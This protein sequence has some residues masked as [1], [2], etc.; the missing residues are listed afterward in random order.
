MNNPKKDKNKSD[1]KIFTCDNMNISLNSQTDSSSSENNLTKKSSS[2]Y[3]QQ[4]KKIMIVDDN[5][6]INDSIKHLIE[7][8]IREFKLDFEVIQGADGIDLLKALV[9]DQKQGNLIECVFTD[10]NM[11]YMNGSEAIRIIRDME[12]S[13]KIKNLKLFSITGQEDIQSS[14]VILASGADNVLGKP[15]NK[16]LLINCFIDMKLI[17]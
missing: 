4:S 9:D 15:V 17:R 2:Q 6:F 3:R 7:S 14:K 11:E 5:K 12:K 8:I 13:N 10:E 16:S 1:D